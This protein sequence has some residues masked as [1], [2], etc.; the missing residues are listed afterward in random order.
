MILFAILGGIVLVAV[1][2]I[3]FLFYLMSKEVQQPKVEQVVPITDISKLKGALKSPDAKKLEVPVIQPIV[4]PPVGFSSTFEVEKAQAIAE[5]NYQKKIDELQNELKSIAAKADEQSK[6]ALESVEQLKVENEKLKS[7]QHAKE[8]AVQAK[9]IQAQGEVDSMRQEQETLQKR[10]QDGQVEV[11]KLK[12]EIVAIE[13][14][15]SA[16]VFK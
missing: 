15:M 5:A 3:G 7:E 14:K 8:L 1:G 9:L 2:V 6:Q 13:Q 11:G 10:L 12:E 16:E 4:S